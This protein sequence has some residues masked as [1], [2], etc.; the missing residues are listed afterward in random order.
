MSKGNKLLIWKKF[1]VVFKWTI[2][3]KFFFNFDF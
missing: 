1:A 2:L 3:G